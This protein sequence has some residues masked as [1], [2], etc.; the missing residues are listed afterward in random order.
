MLGDFNAQI[1]QIRHP[2][3]GDPVDP[4]QNDNGTKLSTLIEQF[5]L[6]LPSTF[7]GIHCG[8]STTWRSTKCP[9]GK[10]LDYIA[11]PFMDSWHVTQSWCDYEIDAGQIWDDH[12]AVAV[13][14]RFSVRSTEKRSLHLRDI[15]RDAIRA[16][17]N[18]E[19]IKNIFGQ[20]PSVQWNVDVHCHYEQLTQHLHQEL[21]S[22]FP[23]RRSKPRKGYV[24]EQSWMMWRQKG[25]L[26]QTQR[27]IHRQHAKIQLTFFFHVWSGRKLPDASQA[28]KL[29]FLLAVNISTLNSL[30]KQLKK[31]LG[32]DRL[33]HLDNL[34]SEV[35]NA[36]PKVV[37]QQLR[38]LGIGSVF[39]KRGPRTL[40]ALN[41]PDGKPAQSV[42]E[43]QE[44]WRSFAADLEFGHAT[45]HYDLWRDCVDR[46]IQ[47]QTALCA[48]S[49]FT[50]P[51]LIQLEWACRKVS[52]RKA[53][54]PDGLCGEIFH[55]FPV[56]CADALQSLAVKIYC[57]NMEPISAKG[58]TLVRAW[59][60]KGDVREPSSYRGLL[61]SNHISKILH[62]VC[63]K[64]ILPFY[65][66]SALP[67]QIGGVRRA[68]VT[69]AGQHI[70]A[71][72]SWARRAAFPAAVLFLDVKTAFYR[73]V[74]PL[75]ARS[76]HLYDQLTG[77]IERFN[78]PAS[79][80][81]QLVALLDQPSAMKAA[82][83]PTSLEHLIGELHESTWFEVP[84]LPTLTATEAGTRPGDPL[85][86]ICFNF[87]FTSV[88]NR[89][90][91]HLEDLGILFSL[92]WAGKR[93]LYF[94]KESSVVEETLMEAVW[95]DDLALLLHC[96][97][98][99]ELAPRVQKA[100]AVLF[101]ECLGAGLEPNLTRGKTETVMSIRGKNSVKARKLVY[102]HLQSQLPVTTTHW[103]EVSLRVV[104]AY[105]HLGGRVLFNGSD[106]QEIFTRFAQARQ[107][108]K[109]YRKRIF[110]S[111]QISLEKRTQ[112]LLPLI[113]SVLEYGMGTWTYFTPK[114][115]R[116]ASAQ[117]ISIYKTLLR[118]ELPR[119]RILQM[120]HQEVLARVQL[121]SWEE[122]A[123][124][125]RLRHFGGLMLEGPL[126]LWA[127][128]EHEMTWIQRVKESFQ[129]MYE[130]LRSSIRLGP[131]E[132]TWPDWNNILSKQPSTWKGWIRRAQKHA[133]LV[134]LNQWSVAHWHCVILEKM[135]EIGLQPSWGTPTSAIPTQDHLCG[136]C[137]LRFP[138]H[139][140][141]SVHAF[142]MHGRT[143][144]L[145]QFL[146]TTFCRCCLKEFWSTRRLHRHL[147]YMQ[148]CASF[149]CAN[150]APQQPPPGLNSKAQIREEPYLLAPPV[151]LPV[152]VELNEQETQVDPETLPH[153]PL[154]DHLVGAFQVRPVQQP[155]FHPRCTMWSLVERIRQCFLQVPISMQHVRLTWNS[156]CCD[157]QQWIHEDCSVEE[158]ATWKHVVDVV[159]WKL[160]AAWL[161]PSST[162]DSTVDPSREAAFM[163]LEQEHLPVWHP[164]IPPVP[165]APPER[166]IVH[167]FS[168]RRRQFDLQACL[169]E[170]PC[171]D[172]VL[173]HV[174][175]VDIV[176]GRN[177][178]LLRRESR[179]IWL[180]VFAA[181]LVLAFFSGPPCETYSVARYHQIEGKRLRPLRSIDHQWGLRSLSLREQ[182][183]VIVANMLIL[184][185]F[186]CFLLQ[187]VGGH[188]GMLE[189][190]EPSSDAKKP[191]IWRT[192]IW[193]LLES[194]N[195][196]TICVFQGLYGA[197]S[198]K[199]TRLAF[200]PQQAD[201]K[202]TLS[203]YQ[204]TDTL[205]KASS[206]GLSEDGSFKTAQ[207]KEYPAALN[208]A[209]A[210]VFSRWHH[211]VKTSEPIALP[212]DLQALLRQ[213]EVTAESCMGPD[214][215]PPT[216]ALIQTA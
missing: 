51:T 173:L 65:E 196:Q 149:Y 58:G 128:L 111:P 109:Q 15:D 183:Q 213:F 87:V 177:A 57:H 118:T 14:L 184:F 192:Q 34:A 97:D 26:K 130:Q 145:R 25:K 63:R 69:F 147:Q 175:S 204:T 185:S 138:S 77:I 53:T 52:F 13:F 168:G 39:R 120:S 101:D 2:F 75:I 106:S 100:A 206:I 186:L 178:D 191:A 169:E 116:K 17:E 124:V 174:V 150:V 79:A 98:A 140:A 122:L 189:H 85:A 167:L 81:Q 209:L 67:L 71:F 54:G 146:T 158:L 31:Q 55:A 66:A 48:P 154:I 18:R 170:I 96:H 114:V 108:L 125:S 159:Q 9:D 41:C 82:G 10:R 3:C 148:K 113:L 74:R 156:F 80:L 61:I 211:N 47:Q 155:D 90:R 50:F 44:L 76:P 105:T 121:P 180:R 151:H 194:Y 137:N 73:I 199:P 190:P 163:W 212:E 141:W 8:P 36:P 35:E 24:S 60:K 45:S 131:P 134:R 215:V 91:G 56:E 200:T 160:C 165:R 27:D 6:W 104:P 216:T 117:L 133:I 176:F 92:Q 84:N 110:Q 78:L 214:Y 49:F 201:L 72:M 123:H 164:V 4:L 89:L 172:G 1:S 99:E 126:P 83:V 132:E 197:V 161:V 32:D 208:R 37:Y 129:W 195:T 203:K 102:V 127:L 70:R 11:V 22:R 182:R 16:P 29:D 181:K 187:Q 21:V 207:L 143:Q 20:L 171:P 86:D 193:R 95:A 115:E 198:P 42:Q 46:Q 12:S 202:M 166:F 139:S 135:N 7:T 157:W 23:Q 5:G 112:L 179:S 62:S 136:P 33:Q 68:R 162:V 40:P 205:P 94:E 142:K 103:G 119:E 152:V 59:K 153:L 30:Q 107:L 43:T 210:G 144:F 88:L 19:I 38:G 64:T 188:F 28:R 93:T